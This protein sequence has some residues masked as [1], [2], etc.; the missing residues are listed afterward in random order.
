MRS[1]AELCSITRVYLMPAWR[2][3][4][5]GYSYTL[6]LGGRAIVKDSFDPDTDLARALLELGIRGKAEVYDAR[7]GRPRTMVDIERVVDVG[8][9]CEAVAS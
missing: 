3:A 6:T 1:K 2:G 8:D 4:V 9:P 7:T 5:H